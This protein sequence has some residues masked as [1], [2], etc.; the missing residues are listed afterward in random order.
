MVTA[1][2]YA[3]R[4]R[5]ALEQAG[6][7]DAAFEAVQLLEIA[8]VCARRTPDAELSPA[9][10]EQLDSLLE[11]RLRRIPLQYLAGE[12]DFWD[13]T[14]FVGEGVL[15]PRP[16]TELCAMLA[17]EQA[18]KAGKGA[19]VLDL[20]SGSGVIALGVALHCAQVNVTAVELSD[21]ALRYLQRNNER[22][23]AP[24]RVVQADVLTWHQHQS[25]ETWDVIASN[26]PY[27][28]EE[29]YQA[30]APELFYEPKMALTAPENGLAFYRCIIPAYHR[31]LK[32][33]GWMV[34]EIGETKGEEVAALYRADGYTDIQLHRD[35][36]GLPRVVMA[37]KSEN[38]AAKTV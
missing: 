36:A 22:H 28:T 6:L 14:V 25:A 2:E 31:L 37:R 1:R 33:G 3:A 23:G 32:P 19:Q 26:P 18:A 11:Q 12:W 9:Q 5:E 15:I 27:V 4:L 34:L 16:D 13:F 8:G 10:C 17:A 38:D 29:E 21:A 20:C 24:C 30:L 7:E 35:L